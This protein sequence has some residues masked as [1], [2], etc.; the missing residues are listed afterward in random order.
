M[1]LSRLS[2]NGN[3]AAAM[4]PAFAVV[5]NAIIAPSVMIQNPAF[6]RLVRPAASESGVR[7]PASSF[8][9]TTPTVTMR[10]QT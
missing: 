10:P 2:A 3:R 8:P 4:I 9:G 7:E 6:P 1:S 5:T